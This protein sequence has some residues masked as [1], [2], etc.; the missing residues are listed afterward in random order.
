MG[1]VSDRFLVSLANGTTTIGCSDAGCIW[2]SR[3]VVVMVASIPLQSELGIPR[4]RG[5]RLEGP[6]VTALL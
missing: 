5:I 3:P 4:E 2:V 1:Q 6:C